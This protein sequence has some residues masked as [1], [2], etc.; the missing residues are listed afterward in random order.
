MV[1]ADI[2][3]GLVPFMLGLLADHI[4][5]H[6]ALALTALCYGW[7]IFYALRGSRGHLLQGSM[8]RPGPPFK[9]AVRGTADI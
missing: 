5:V 9:A 4:G 8:S 6:H 7:A 3:A 2:G 1:S